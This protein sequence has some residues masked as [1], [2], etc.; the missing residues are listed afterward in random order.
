MTQNDDEVAA[1]IERYLAVKR[2][3]AIAETRVRCEIAK[4]HR[5]ELSP[6]ACT[7]EAVE[8]AGREQDALREM[9]EIEREIRVLSARS[10][11][12]CVMTAIKAPAPA[13]APAPPADEAAVTPAPEPTP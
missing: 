3:G 6:D 11:E 4:I 1:L 12:E 10:L 13:P 7:T 2:R 8:W 9:G 5:P